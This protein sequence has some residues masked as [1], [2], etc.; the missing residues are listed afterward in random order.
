MAE[1]V[2]AEYFGVFENV[3]RFNQ[4]A[5]V[6]ASGVEHDA[7]RASHSAKLIVKFVA[8]VIAMRLGY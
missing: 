5:G 8:S 1:C 7:K 3:V 6:A 4:A 2:P